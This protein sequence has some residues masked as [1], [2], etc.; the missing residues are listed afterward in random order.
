MAAATK[1]R[2]GNYEQQLREYVRAASWLQAQ[3]IAGRQG[4]GY[5][6][7]VLF[8][9]GEDKEAREGVFR[10]SQRAGAVKADQGPRAER[11]GQALAGRG[12][13][14]SKD[15]VSDKSA[16]TRGTSSLRAPPCAGATTDTANAGGWR[17]PELRG[18]R[19]SR[20]G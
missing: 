18:G 4:F 6:S 11:F 5:D 19:R 14:R 20:P 8:Q 15:Q 17:C 10:Q 7:G 3:I 12:E 2:E 13:G 16:T 1:A 9:L